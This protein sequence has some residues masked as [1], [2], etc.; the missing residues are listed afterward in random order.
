MLLVPVALLVAATVVS[1][2]PDH[3]VTARVTPLP[4]YLIFRVLELGMLFTPFVALACIAAWRTWVHARRY[5]GGHG[6]GWSGVGEGGALGLFLAV[7]VLSPGIIAHPAAAPP[8]IAFYGGGGLILGLAMGLVLRT[9]AL[10][11][12]RRSVLP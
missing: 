3:T 12:L 6:S 8:Y 7:L 5:L 10:L 11:V 4:V 2:N 1:W 9:S